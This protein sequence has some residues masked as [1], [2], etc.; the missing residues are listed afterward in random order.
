MMRAVLLGPTT[1]RFKGGIAH[2]THSLAA[3]LARC[4][5]TRVISFSRPYPRLLYPGASELTSRA[6]APADEA[7]LLDWANPLSWRRAGIAAADAQPE[8]VFVQWW[9]GFWAAPTW[10]FV[11]L[12]RARRPGAR[13]VGIVHNLADHDSVPFSAA[14]GRRVLGRCDALVTHAAAM[15]DV[16]QGRFPDTPVATLPMPAFDLFAGDMESTPTQAEAQAQVG[17]RSPLLL[18]FGHVRPYKGLDVLL[19]ALA[20]LGPRLPGLTLLVVGE[21][22]KESRAETAALIGALGLEGRVRVVDRYV[23]DEEVPIYFRAADAAVLPYR[24]ATGTAVSKVALA[25]GTPLIATAVGDLPD[26]FAREPV[27]VI[28]APEDPS[29]L[30]KAVERFY[31]ADRRAFQAAAQRAAASLTWD[32]FARRLLEV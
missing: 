6:P 11:R 9:S 10:Q 4:A 18:F 5:E 3:A 16:L 24:S 15:A 17:A 2:Y 30:A 23:A 20:E 31:A 28:C 32:A 26:L 22:W 25:L 27:G 21:F 8:R 29:A 14:A 13:V 12:L 7:P 1:P 19:R